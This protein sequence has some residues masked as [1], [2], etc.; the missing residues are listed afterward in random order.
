VP[1]ETQVKPLADGSLWLTTVVKWTAHT[2]DTQQI[3]AEAD[4]A[5]YI[6]AQ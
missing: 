3:L 5:C 2:A 6:V 4:Q 1:P